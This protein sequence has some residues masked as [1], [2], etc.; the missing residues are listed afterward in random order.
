MN[1]STVRVLID[2]PE[3]YV[4]LLNATLQNPNPDGKGD[5]VLLRFASLADVIPKGEV[6]GTVTRLA[7][8]L[9]PTTRTMRAEVHLD[10]RAG[11]LRPNM[12]GEAT[13]YLERRADRT[14]IPS[15]AIQRR[16]GTMEV[17]YVEDKSLTG[18]PPRGVLRSARVELGLDDG[19]QVEIRNRLPPNI[20]VI[21][22]STSTLAEGDTVI[23]VPM[24]EHEP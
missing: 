24:Q 10:N 8:A 9:D 1:V 23:P 16:L 2:V 6:R 20:R 17:L 3:R 15:T 14:V 18:D 21:A 12:T 5:V 11:H 13:V 19:L 7:A 4:P 22:R